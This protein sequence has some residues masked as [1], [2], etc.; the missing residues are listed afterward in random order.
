[1]RP[2]VVEIPTA[3][4]RW[5]S[6]VAIFSLVLVAAALFL[7]RLF[8][9]PTPVAINLVKLAYLGAAAGLLL[10]AAAAL[11]IW[12]NGSAGT[13]RVVVTALVGVGMIGAPLLVYAVER[14]KP[15]I[16]DVT[17]DPM[18]P[19]QF[20]T[21]RQLRDPAANP[22]DYGGEVV[23]RAQAQAYPDLKPMRVAR[24]STEAFELVTDAVRREQMQIVSE[25]PPN[26]ETGE[27]GHL[28]AV[29]RTLILG[30]YDDVAIRVS[31]EQ[32]GSRVDIRSQS[33]FG[34]HDFGRNAERMRALMR[35]IAVR[36]EETV[37]TAEDELKARS[38]RALK[39]DG[40]G[41]QKS[42]GA[43]KSRDRAQ[44][45]ARRELEQKERRQRRDAR[46]YRRRPPA[47][48][49]E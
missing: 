21:V 3:L 2:P 13:A 6:R 49:Y 19:P 40:E 32:D 43:R 29:D 18:S 47:Q 15:H 35:Q 46:R 10:A 37:P 7:H 42:A 1:M 11:G 24:S 48:W 22:V 27:P 39:P 45:D 44:S 25:V 26:E 23:A 33:R 9:M 41:D 20:A 34:S 12:R 17:T 30:F 5:A 36:L 14:D 38:K 31:P 4:S 16:N 8:G 28:E